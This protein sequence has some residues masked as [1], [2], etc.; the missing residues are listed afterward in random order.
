[1]ALR[2]P[3]DIAARYGG[4]EFSA[5]LP[6]TSPEQALAIAERVRQSVLAM[7]LLHEASQVAKIVTVSIGVATLY[8][9]DAE[10]QLEVLIKRADEALYKAK[11]GGRNRACQAALGTIGDSDRHQ[12]L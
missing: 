6:N 12:G 11:E 8:P 1:M 9:G 10:T 7:D 2:K 3:A 5:I 4:E